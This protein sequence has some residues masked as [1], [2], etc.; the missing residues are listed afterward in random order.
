MF[1]KKLVFIAA[2]S[3]MF[4][5]GIVL[6]TLGA[7]LPSIMDK[8]QINKID[9]GSLMSFLSIG[10]LISSMI[11]GPIADRHVEYCQQVAARLRDAGMRVEVDDST[12]RMQ[13]KIRKAQG[14]KV[15]YMLVVGGREQEERSV[16]IRVRTG[17]K[18]DLPLS[19]A[20]AMILE[21][22]ASKSMP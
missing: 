16:S 6:T 3:G 15:P 12:E 11:F 2:C 1:N 7:I 18:S 19:D 8:F 17:E 14:Q 9:A 13:N 21:K 22:I 10:I 20:A 5:F 4:L